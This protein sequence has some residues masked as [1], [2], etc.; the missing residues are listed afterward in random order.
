[1][2]KVKVKWGKK[3]YDVDL[4][5]SESP[6]VFKSQ[7]FALTNVPPERQKIMVKGGTLKDD[8]NW[9]DLGIKDGHVFMMMGTADA[10]LPKQPIDKPI[11]MEDLSNDEKASLE[12]FGYPAGLNNLGNTCYM[13]STLQCLKAVPELGLALKK[14]SGGIKD[15]DNPNNLTVALRDLFGILSHSNQPIPPLV[16]LQI[17]RTAFPQFAQKGNNGEWMQ[18]DAEECYTQLLLSLS[19]KLPKVGEQGMGNSVV[20]QLFS[21][22]MKTETSN[23]ENPAEEKTSR[24]ETFTKLSCHIKSNTNFLSE[25]IK[26][27]LEEEITKNSESLGKEAKYKRA[28]KITK[29]PYYAT[30]QF[31]RFF[32]KQQ[33]QMKAKIVRPVEFPFTL[34]LYEFCS[35]ELKA[36][37]APKRKKFLEEEEKRAEDSRKKVK[38]ESGK[39]EE[40]KTE[41]QPTPMDITLDPSKFVNDSGQYELFAVMTHKGRM[42]DGGHYVAWVKESNDKWAKFDDEKVSYVNNEEIKKLTGKGGGDWHM[43]YLL[44]YRTIH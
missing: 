11:F 29:L 38:G 35:D 31:V 44:L 32:W 24:N 10:E 16:F 18:Q 8:G 14:Y 12:S 41:S 20:S 5:M 39:Q 9:G 6:L 7:L 22:E 27:S 42:A 15:G 34:D 17:M 25:G 21:G 2:L 23:V 26:D 40:K 37:L 1:M 28:S 4:N 3:Q 43:A 30:V 19:Q 36:Q 33:N 13:N